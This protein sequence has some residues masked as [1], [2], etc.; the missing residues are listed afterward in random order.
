MF[1][2]WKAN[3]VK[4]LIARLKPPDQGRVPVAPPI[5]EM[6]MDNVLRVLKPWLTTD[7]RSCRLD[8][9]RILQLA[10][11][12]DSHMNEQWSMMYATSMPLEYSVR[13][14]FPFDNT[15]METTTKEIQ[16]ANSQPV[17]I[18]VAPALLRFGTANGDEYDQTWVLVRSRV[19]PQ[20][21]WSSTQRPKNSKTRKGMITESVQKR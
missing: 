13:H 7:E 2:K 11:D 16:M 18:V 15:L 9:K 14:G 12:F 19:L 1:Y 21:F 17:G 8:L 20:G 10:I 4:L 6:L 5:F 3:T